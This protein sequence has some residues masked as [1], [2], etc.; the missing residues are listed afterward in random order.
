MKKAVC[1]KIV[2]S[3]LLT[4]ISV[5]NCGRIGDI[6]GGSTETVNAR[7]SARVILSDSSAVSGAAVR[8]IPS[9]QDPLSSGALIYKDTTDQSGFFS[10]EVKDKA[11]SDGY[12]NILVSGNEKCHFTDSMMIE[13]RSKIELQDLMLKDPGSLSGTVIFEEGTIPDTAYAVLV[14]TDLSTVVVSGQ[15]T[16][17]NIPEGFYTLRVITDN[18]GYS[19]SNQPVAI[20]SLSS[21]TLDDTL[22]I[23]V[24]RVLLDDFEDGDMFLLNNRADINEGWNSF[25]YVFNEKDKEPLSQIIPE[26]LLVQDSLPLAISSD[27]AYSGKSI[28]LKTVLA[29]RS[30]PF[31]GLGCRITPDRNRYSNL[32]NMS[33]LSFYMRGKGTVRVSFLTAA[34]NRYPE[35]QR[36]GT[37]GKYIECPDQWQEITIKASEFLPQEYSPQALDS[38]FWSDVSDSVDFLQFVTS[39]SAGDTVEFY[40]DN[41]WL[42]GVDAEDLM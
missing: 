34:L 33:S 12:Y 36:W 29:Q 41:I 35:A 17:N 4:L 26:G 22:K 21:D 25:W 27:G 7:V 9:G 2:L 3:F 24:L 14:G 42:T 8:I 40:L 6:S 11:F 15:F 1:I 20:T 31:A 39:A 37:W 13:Q 32:S 10:L 28:H 38:L 16:F 18:A 23:P 19:A 30:S 5:I